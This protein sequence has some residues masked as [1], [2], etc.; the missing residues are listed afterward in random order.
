MTFYRH[1]IIVPLL[2]ILTACGGGGGGGT[3][4]GAALI[5]ASGS[6]GGSTGGSNSTATVSLSANTYEIVAGDRTTLTW[7]SSNASSC[8]ASGS[9]SGSKSLSGNESITLDNY[10]DYTFSIDCSG[11][12]ASIQVTVSDND[13]E[14]SCQNPHSAKI[15]KSYMGDY[16]LP[17]PQNSFGD[18]HI[19]AIG[20][21]DYGVE[22]VYKNYRDRGD[23]WVS[24]CTQDEYI[25]LMYRTTLR[26]LKENGVDTAWVYNFGYWQDDQADFWQISHN[27]KH[28][29]DWAIEYIAETAQDLGMNIHY[30]WQFLTFDIQNQELFPFNGQAYVDMALL[31]K[32]MDAHEEHMLWEADRLQQLGVASMSADWSAMYICMCGLENEAPSTERDEMK[33]YYMERLASIINQI[34]GRFD[35]NVYVGEGI[36]WNDSRVLD[37][38]DGVIINLPNLL[39]DDEV[40][41]ATVEL[42]EE[43]ASEYATML[44]DN[45]NCADIHQ[46]CW[47]Y[48]TYDMPKVIWNMFAQSHANFLSTGW[49]E[50][51]F[52]TQG[53]Y[54]DVYYDQCLQYNVPTDFSAQAIWIE[55]LLRAIDKQPWF[56]TIGTTA[57]TA[58]WLSDTLIPDNNQYPAG[59][60]TIEGFPNISQSVRGKPAE[61]I[62]KAWYTGQYDTYNPEYE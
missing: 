53:T 29:D 54:K 44:Y 62:I 26:K 10:G 19:K 38:V 15:K 1:I 11:A 13:S 35:G 51:G 20:F 46:P 21:K 45:W 48:T 36:L 32:I 39:F 28:I 25:K 57:S 50:D 2:G 58:Y 18:D 30:A 27:N 5:T 60:N 47:E 23:S 22:W 7:S 12:T 37:I 61:K 40:A 55:G 34:K 9:W 43:R 24:D 52:C 41:G 16:E 49:V 56:E 8:T 17:M 3:D 14:G 42:L 33:H 59:S 4:V 6:T 31:K